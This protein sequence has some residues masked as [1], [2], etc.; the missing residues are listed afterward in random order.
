M[1]DLVRIFVS[2][3]KC[4]VNGLR[5]IRSIII[6]IS[7]INNYNGWDLSMMYT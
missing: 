5:N 3:Y 2:V 1:I 7:I 6:G 4:R